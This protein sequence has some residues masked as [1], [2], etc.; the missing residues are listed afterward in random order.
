MQ[1][2]F[3]LF[4][5][6]LVVLAVQGQ[7]DPC[8]PGYDYWPHFFCSYYYECTSDGPVVR[9]C[10]DP[11]FWNQHTTQCEPA[12]NVPECDGG[13]RDPSGTT[14]PVTG[15][16]STTTVGPTGTDTQPP[17]TT[18]TGNPNPNGNC[19]E[20]GT[21]NIPYPGDC[22]KYMTCTNF[23]LAP[24]V[25]ECPSMTL[26]DPVVGECNLADLVECDAPNCPTS[27]VVHL[28]YFG[29][30]SLYWICSDGDATLRQ[31]PPGLIYDPDL[32]VCNIESQV[33]CPWNYRP[34]CPVKGI[35]NLPHEKSCNLYWSCRNG[36]MPSLRQCEAGFSFDSSMEECTIKSASNNKVGCGV[37]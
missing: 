25:Y 24:V 34:L 8:P 29:N 31:C 28:P 21:Y 4:V 16:T 13:T 26:F 22:S 23:N 15:T 27:G 37:D 32:T 7:D 11:L 1:K 33:D 30:C 14:V 10:D 20:G 2:V 9:F 6:C 18:T 17:V 35:H 19:T 5:A 12:V 36:R 3:Q